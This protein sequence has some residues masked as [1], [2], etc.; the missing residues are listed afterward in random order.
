MKK[1]TKFQV[2]HFFSQLRKL[3]SLFNF[4][5]QIDNLGAARQMIDSNFVSNDLELTNEVDYLL[6]RFNSDW[7][8]GVIRRLNVCLSVFDN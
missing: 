8:Y 4:K 7:Y 1:M 3:E 5:L 2:G 6:S